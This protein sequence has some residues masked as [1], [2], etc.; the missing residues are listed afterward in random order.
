MHGGDL[1]C[2][3]SATVG[4]RENEAH[5]TGRMER[6]YKIVRYHL[7]FLLVIS[8]NSSPINW[9]RPKKVPSGVF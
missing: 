5:E 6:C 2:T 8:S 3:G 7:I 1:I 4:T 9:Q